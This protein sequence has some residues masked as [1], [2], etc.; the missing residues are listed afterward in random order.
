M[1]EIHYVIGEQLDPYINAHTHGLENSF[2]HTDLQIVMPFG[3]YGVAE[4][5]SDCIAR[6][7]DGMVII[8]GQLYAGLFYSDVEFIDAIESDRR[9]LRMLIPDDM[10]S[11][12]L[13]ESCN[14]LIHRGQVSLLT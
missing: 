10:G 3:Q 11:S 8:P 5:F 2:H 14:S 9:V 4:I 12:P 13:S 6:I 7:N 1:Y